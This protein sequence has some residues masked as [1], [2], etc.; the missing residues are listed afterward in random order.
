MVKKIVFRKDYQLYVYDVK[1]K[2]TKLVEIN[3]IENSTLE[4]TQDFNVQGKISFFDVS[5]D[6]KKLC[7]V[8]RGELFVSDAKGKFVKQLKTSPNGR[9]MEAHFLK[10]DKSIIF[11]QTVNGYQNWF[12]I[13]ANGKTAAVRR[14]NGQPKTIGISLS[15][16]IRPRLLIS[17]GALLCA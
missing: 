2:N 8:S 15:T 11:S 6:G 12:T 14:T 10:D 9:V 17:V 5:N 4:K 16:A 1:K 3:T 7:F 13:D